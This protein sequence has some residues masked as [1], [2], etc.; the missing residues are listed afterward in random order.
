MNKN[1][2]KMTASQLTHEQALARIAELESLLANTAQ[3]LGRV[4]GFEPAELQLDSTP[5]MSPVQENEIIPNPDSILIAEIQ[6]QFEKKGT[7]NIW[8][9]SSYSRIAQLECDDVGRTGENIIQALCEHL[10]IISSIN[11]TLTK[12][13]G[14]GGGGDGT[15]KGRSV[16]IKTARAGTGSI[17]SFQHEL[18]EKPWHA[19]YMLFIDLAPH[20][21]WIH[22][23][24]NHSEEFYRESGK[25]GSVLKCN[26]WGFP[27]KKITHRKEV[28]AFKFDTT[29][30][31]NETAAKKNGGYTFCVTHP[32]GDET[33]A[34]FINRIIP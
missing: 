23:L 12:A 4:M 22:L 21:W 25:K 5:I 32:E 27:T 8:E 9:N 16:E 14:G 28:G 30:K 3:G 17:M 24:P 2:S 26:D 6:K 20:K 18:G 15:I 1:I 34:E 13:A 29:E 33:L 10:G 19:D 11:G 31:L 7:R